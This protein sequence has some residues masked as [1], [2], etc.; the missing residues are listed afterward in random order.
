MRT[1][2]CKAAIRTCTP[3]IDVCDDWEST[4]RMLDADVRA[5]G[6]A[7][8][9]MGASPGIGNLLAARAAARLD[10]V[11]D[12]Y[13]A[14]PVDVLPTSGAE[15]T[16]LRGPDGRPT[17]AGRWHV[18]F[19]VIPEPIP[20]PG[21]GESI[22]VDRGV[23]VSAALSTGELLTVPVLTDS[24]KR[25]LARLERKLVRA[26]RGSKRRDKAKAAVAKLKAR[27]TDRRKDWPRRPAR[28]WPAAST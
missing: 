21:N 2:A 10:I 15:A 26:R 28:I 16:D 8:V 9:G 27:Q 1:S 18:A 17:A 5:A 19:A 14:W 23:T 7:V 24:E 3:C 25:R 4:L 12:L 13:T 22:G 6:C 20:A 11:I